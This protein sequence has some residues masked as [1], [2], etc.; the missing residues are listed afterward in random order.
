MAIL[1]R[2]LARDIRREK[3]RY[4]AVALLVF[5]G[6]TVY[7][8]IWFSYKGLDQSYRRT[9][10]ELKYNDIFI[11]TTPAPD[12]SVAGLAALDGV[13]AVVGRLVVDTGGRMPDGTEIKVHL[14]GLP[15]AGRPPVNDLYIKKGDYFRPGDGAAGVIESHLDEYYGFQPGDRVAIQTSAGEREIEVRGVGASPEYFVLYSEGSEYLATADNYGVIF[16]PQAWLQEAMGMPGQ[17]NEYCIDTSEGADKDAVLAAAQEALPPGSV[18]Y[19]G[20]GAEHPARELLDIDVQM[21]RDLSE[22]F[23]LLFMIV[24]AFSLYMIITRLV[25]SQRKT[26]GTMMSCGMKP[27]KIVLHYLSYSLMIWAAGSFLGI[28]AGYFL[29]QEITKMYA[30]SMGIPLVTAGMDWGAAALGC[31]VTLLICVAAGW[32]P[33]VKLLKQTPA[34][35]L[36]GEGDEAGA[37]HHHLLPAD[38]KDQRRGVLDR[39]LPFLAH[40]S[41]TATLP[42]RNL[43]RNRRRTI[44]NVIT[45]IFAIALILVA[46]C[47]LDSMNRVIDF[48]FR[49][50]I[51]YD[52]EV[53]FTEP[54]TLRAGGRVDL[55]RRCGAGGSPDPGPGPLHPG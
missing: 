51:N 21:F 38:Q 48:H 44:F 7:T 37:H 12:S 4:F 18:A 40:M 35:V 36:K 43:G 16:V 31:A 10:E 22:F 13:E 41:L 9:S 5:L 25:F 23:P 39:A 3:G 32:I 27:D 2:K 15:T 46:V 42:L 1:H 28:V 30:D 50:Y 6:M 19:A 26:I 54:V 49:E 11:R 24:A 29:A 53:A 33:L 52:A 45:F 17:I 14:I 34:E 8:S 47:G 20:L 55:H